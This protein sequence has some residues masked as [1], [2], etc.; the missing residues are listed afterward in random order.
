MRS[1]LRPPES[2]RV[3][4]SSCCTNVAPVQRSLEFWLLPQDQVKGG[5]NLASKTQVRDA[6]RNSALMNSYTG[7][8]NNCVLLQ[9]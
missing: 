2:G 4:A 9:R 7:A 8:K 6:A 3:V 1:D 5:M